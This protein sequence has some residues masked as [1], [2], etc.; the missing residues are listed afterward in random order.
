MSARI[1]VA[2]VGGG[3][4]GLSFAIALAKSG[5]PVDVDLY[6][7]TREF[8]E[9]G[10]GIAFQPRVWEA[11]RMLCLE[12]ELRP[13]SSA[14]IPAYYSKGDEEP[15]VM[16]GRSGGTV[17]SYHRAEFLAALVHHL[18]ANYRTHFSKRLVSYTDAPPARLELR[19]TDGTTATCDLL[20]GADGVKSAVRA[21]MYE[22]LAAGAEDAG[23]AEHFRQCIPA[24]WT[25]QYVYRGMVPREQLERACPNHPAL[26]GPIFFMGKDKFLICYPVSSGTMINVGGIVTNNAACGSLHPEPW[27][28]PVTQDEFRAQYT[29][30][31][32]YV[33]HVINGIKSPSRWATNSVPD[34][35]TFT[36]GRVAII[37][38]AAHAMTPHLGSGAA[39]GV[40]DGLIGGAPCVP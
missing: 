15:F 4:A 11:M 26:K 6:E 17:D 31:C 1:S 16:F 29:G 18:P 38:D 13:K 10:A 5:A 7:S 25:G 35:P 22:G 30:W 8:S 28:V 12:D 9:V 3:I 37:G 33:Q 34:L 19:F 24:K 36:A 2:I 39:Q 32:S 23:Q 21:A 27:V 40:E 14:G 20:V